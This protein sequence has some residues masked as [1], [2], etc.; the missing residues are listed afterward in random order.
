MFY[1][2]EAPN[3]QQN[4]LIGTIHSEDE[5]VL[6]FPPVLQQALIQ[7]DRL[8]L[9]LVPD[10]KMLNALDQAMRLPPGDSLEGRIGS[11]LYRKTVDVL[12]EYGFDERE[13]DRMAPWAVA[14]TLALPPPRT[15]LFMDM[16]LAAAASRH[17]AELIALET[18]DEQLQFM[19]A[20][21]ETAHL[22]MLEIALADFENGQMMFEALIEAYRVGCLDTLQELAFEEFEK[23]G[24]A[25]GATFHQSGLVDRNRRMARRVQ[26]LLDR[27]NTLIA[28]GALHLPGGEGLIALL[29]EQGNEVVAVY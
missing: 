8:A 18:L 22:R 10:Q 4:W 1:T 23:M 3:G 13:I 12:K 25:L 11:D 29:R 24:P 20:L 6:D 14:V 19:T 21:G 27:G 17:G 2:V 15:G 9:E 28:V 7:A 26:T 5:R 16:A